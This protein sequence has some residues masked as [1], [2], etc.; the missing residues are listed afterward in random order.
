MLAYATGNNRAGDPQS[1]SYGDSGGE[2]P[3]V[4][5]SPPEIASEGAAEGAS[6]GDLEAQSNNGADPQAQ[7]YVLNTNTHRF[8][9]PYCSSVSAMKEK[10]KQVF[11]GTREEVI[12]QGYQP[13]VVC[14]P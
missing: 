13:C 10:N 1:E 6:E 9:Y 12:E 7:T 3:A 14:K 4:A 11:E 8:H 2:P 5:V